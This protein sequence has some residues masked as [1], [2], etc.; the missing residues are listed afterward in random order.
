[1]KTRS[2][3]KRVST[4]DPEWRRSHQK[5]AGCDGEGLVSSGEE[6]WINHES[7]IVAATKNRRWG[8]LTRCRSLGMSNLEVA[9]CS[10]DDDASRH[11]GDL[12]T[13]QC[14]DGCDAAA[15][16]DKPKNW[17]WFSQLNRMP[18]ASLK[19]TW[20]RTKVVTETHRGDHVS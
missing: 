12:A 8:V 5:A 19:A 2:Q 16:G 9:G 11:H 1:M 14:R 4:R 15:R 13:S 7:E 20:Q 18:Q 10:Y 17:D 6:Q 3:R